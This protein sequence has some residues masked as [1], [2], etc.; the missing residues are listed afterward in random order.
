MTL[1]TFTLPTSQI[2]PT[3]H[4]FEGEVPCSAHTSRAEAS[5]V[6]RMK[7]TARGGTSE[8]H[9]IENVDP[10]HAPYERSRARCM[11]GWLGDGPIVPLA[12]YSPAVR[13]SRNDLAI[14]LGR[15]NTVSPA[16]SVTPK[17]RDL[18]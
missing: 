14:Q 11:Q 8:A 15:S 10:P 2:G 9:S 4:V 7:L 5:S 13:W 17:V 18:K 12:K 16:F 6:V 3:P 1:V